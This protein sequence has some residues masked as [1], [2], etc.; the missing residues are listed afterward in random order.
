M[1]AP[2]ARLRAVAGA[3]A[4]V[5][6]LLL[7]FIVVLRL[8]VAGVL[9]TAVT[10][11]AASTLLLLFIAAAFRAGV[12][13]GP[14]AVDERGE[15]R[16]LFRRHGFALLAIATVVLLPMLG[17]FSLVDPWETHYAEVAREMLERRDLISPW[18]AHEGFFMSKPI[19]TFWL[20]AAAMKVFGVGTTPDAVLVASDG[21]VLHPEWA[22]RFPAFALSLVGAYVLYYGVSRTA[23][24]RA[25]LLAG[26]A[27]L[28]M[29]GYGLLSHQAITDMPL[30][31]CTGASLGLLLRA[32]DTTARGTRARGG[33]ARGAEPHSNTSD[34]GTRAR[35]G[36]APPR[37][38]S[39]ILATTYTVRTDKHAVSFHAGH[40][41][42][43][44]VVVLVLFQAGCL[45]LGHVRLDGASIQ[46]RA[47]RLLIG[48]PH[49]CGLPSQPACTVQR[50]AHPALAPALIVSVLV[51]LTLWLA[52]TLA[53]E[54]RLSRLFAIGTW[55]CASLAAMAKGPAG[56]VVPAGA[57]LVVIVARRENALADR[58]QHLARHLMRLEAPLGALLTILLVTPWYL[59][60]YA[61]HGRGY[62]DEL[63][64][65][66]MFGRALE[67]LHDTN[68]GEDV[69]LVYFVRQLGWATFPWSGLLAAAF[70]GLPSRNERSR[71]GLA[72]LAAGGAA[73]VGFALVGMMR[74]KFHHYV[75][76]VLPPC[77]VV[78]GLW[79][80]ERMS[81]LD[82][83][84]GSRIR[85]IHSAVL[86][87][88]AACVTLLVLRDL[89]TDGAARRFIQ[90]LT[91]R[92][93]RRWPTFAASTPVVGAVGL[94]ATAISALFVVGRLRRRATWCFAGAAA[95][96]S[97]VLLDVSLASG[98]KDGGQRR[99]LE[100]YYRAAG[101]RP[102]RPLVAYQL[103]WK[104]ENFYT[105]NHLA[106]FVSSGAPLAKWL[107]SER[108][109][110]DGPFFFVTERGR[111]TGLRAELRGARNIEVLT[112][113][114][115][116]CEFALVRASL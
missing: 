22:V 15:P 65:K 115:D 56:L 55:I 34:R 107:A 99:V 19:L 94:A 35:G 88:L 3:L 53:A 36:E 83:L 58:F 5:A 73:I 84:R 16:P 39:A 18:W 42:A 6:L 102:S 21:T 1:R 4:L 44:I 13:L 62:I 59:A 46:L 61:R 93:D 105:G 25:G 80:D 41:V 57:A 79:L 52:A 64:L 109:T 23:G 77:A 92:Y 29:P 97:V 28:T 68:S 111:V 91:Y 74:T 27:L 20:E 11:L 26:I 81:E 71:R 48:S 32:L 51:P 8:A 2:E 76:L 113:E 63:V 67:H 12:V 30:V 82:K 10:G 72:R 90:L 89:A 114:T 60:V 100:A 38:G 110:G 116:S 95:L 17:A 37:I 33:S 54:R 9:P 98:A 40:A 85:R 45:L 14:L 69:G 7:A 43:V 103:N 66:H 78:V 24:R 47:D 106:I 75:L 50:I 49:A 96:F 86:F 87:A 108:S 112:D 104:G 31:A 70:A 101:A